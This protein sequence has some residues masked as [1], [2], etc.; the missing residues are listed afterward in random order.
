MW[1]KTAHL[2]QSCFVC[3]EIRKNGNT[4]E[5][6]SDEEHNEENDENNDYITDRS[7]DHPEFCLFF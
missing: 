1:G 5:T 3:N 7:F 6:C 2:L 4:K